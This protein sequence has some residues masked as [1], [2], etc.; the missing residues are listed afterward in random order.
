VATS[1]L[2]FAPGETNIIESQ[3]SPSVV[4]FWL[5]SQLAVTNR[6]IV[7]KEPN[8][9]LGVIPLGYRDAAFPLN[10]VASVGVEVK[11]SLGRAILGLIFFIVG[12]ALVTK[13]VLG[14]ILLLIGFSMLAN[15]L[16][17]AL[18]V[19]NNGGGVN[20]VKVSVLQKSKLEQF[21]DEAN[22]RLFAD[23]EGLRHSETMGAHVLN[24]QL[25]AL[26][27]QQT[28]QNNGQ[29]A[30]QSY[31]QP[32]AQYYGQPAA[33]YY[34]QPA[35][36]QPAYYEAPAQQPAYY[37]AQ[38]QQ[39]V[40]YQVGDVVNGHRFDGTTWVPLSPPPPPSYT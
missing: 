4:L 17:A 19:Q 37:E 21:R 6:R 16:S 12:I 2:N 24:A 7:L 11:F 14:I 28:M 10:N 20:F 34:G 30:A 31:G 38:P 29:P 33:Q 1:N 22:Q 27:L 23:T 39:P 35:A 15:A 13:N 36:Q 3:F 8:T 5:R 9:L 25:Q 32:A 40:Y 18:R 26:Q